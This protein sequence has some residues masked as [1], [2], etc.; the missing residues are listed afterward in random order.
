MNVSFGPIGGRT[1][2]E[3]GTQRIQPDAGEF[4]PWRGSAGVDPSRTA[5]IQGIAARFRHPRSAE[6]I[7]VRNESAG[8]AGFPFG[9]GAADLMRRHRKKFGGWKPGL[10]V[11]LRGFRTQCTL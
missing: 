7:A 11:L 3:R 9:R 6:K 1:A 10:R 2:G 8:C 5:E 4:T